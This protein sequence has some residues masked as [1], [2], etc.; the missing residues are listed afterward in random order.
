MLDRREEILNLVNGHEMFPEDEPQPS[1]E[2]TAVFAD[3]LHAKLMRAAGDAE[4]KM[5]V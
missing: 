4:M 3:W 1:S 5:R 2:E